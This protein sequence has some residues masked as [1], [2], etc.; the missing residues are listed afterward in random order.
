MSDW[1]KTETGWKETSGNTQPVKNYTYEEQVIGEW[2]DGKPLY[3]KVL[4]QTTTTTMYSGNNYNLF[5]VA[6]LSIE[7]IVKTNFI[8]SYNNGDAI[9][10][11]FPF[12]YTRVMGGK[13]NVIC[14][15][16]IAN[17]KNIK[18]IMEYT[19]TTD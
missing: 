17:I 3:R 18:A 8:I 15:A 16:G 2:V 9:G 10:N 12:S 5:D 11:D 7:T 1:V 19:K 14:T 13:L 6:N 4:E